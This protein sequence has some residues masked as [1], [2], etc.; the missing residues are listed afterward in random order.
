MIQIY[1]TNYSINNHHNIHSNQVSF[2]IKNPFKLLLS[3][4]NDM[5]ESKGLSKLEDFRQ[6]CY[7]TICK[8]SIALEN[9]T[10]KFSGLELENLVSIG[11]STNINGI[12]PAILKSTANKPLSTSFVKNCSVLYL[13]NKKSNTHL[14]YHMY[15]D[16]NQ[17]EIKDVITLFMPEKP[18]HAFI[19]PGHK[20][21]TYEHSR[22]LPQVF[23]ALKSLNEN[24]PV[25]VYHMSSLNPEIVGYKGQIYEI[26]TMFM[27]T[28]T[29]PLLND[30]LGHATFPISDISPRY[31]LAKIKHAEALEDLSD[32]NSI[33]EN[34][35]PLLK[36]IFK[37]LAN[38]KIEMLKKNNAPQK[39]ARLISDEEF[40]KYKKLYDSIKRLDYFS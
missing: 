3:R 30:T 23:A 16:V 8:G 21:Y 24:V 9:F 32:F 31:L 29:Y 15:E 20:R 17:Q 10:K 14:L 25:N 35:D 13:Y 40:A 34:F 19:V 26:P 37:K 22:Y 1:S 6:G 33:I 36:S 11:Y 27:N 38:E 7:G 39:R 18:S 28:E 5:F 4:N 2:G 12:A